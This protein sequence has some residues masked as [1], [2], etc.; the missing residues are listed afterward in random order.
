MKFP[1]NAKIFRGQLDA[2][3]F[4]GVFFCL[5]LF[6]LLASMVYTP[7]VFIRL[8]VSSAGV[9]GVD[10]PKLA[11]AVAANGQLYFKNQPIQRTNLQQRLQEEVKNC[12][13]PLTLVLQADKG[14]TVEML[15]NLA[16]MARATGITNVLQAT[17]PRGFDSPTGAK[18]VP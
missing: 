7:G 2:T 10:G 15:D 14:V 17:L 1:R 9:P 13:Q 12:A 16:D 4:A 5:V 3:P 11:V 8:P 18:K 6:I